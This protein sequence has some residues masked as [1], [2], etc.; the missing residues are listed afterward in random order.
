MPEDV[1]DYSDEDDQKMNLKNVILDVLAN[2]Y[3]LQGDKGKAFLIHNEITQLGSNPDWAIINDLDKLDKKSNKTAFEKYLI[4]AKVKSSSWDWRTEKST[5]I[6]FKLSDY[7][8]D[9]KGTLY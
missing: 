5:D 7:L 2:R 8:A 4:N 6:Q 3:F 9:F 1:Y